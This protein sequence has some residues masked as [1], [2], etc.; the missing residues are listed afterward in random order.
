LA[1]SDKRGDSPL[2][3]ACQKGFP[4]GAQ[5][6]EFLL[7]A[8][9]APNLAG[10]SGWTPL[11]GA[12]A[13]NYREPWG[14]SSHVIVSE[15]LKNGA[16]VNARSRSGT[17]ALIQPAGHPNR[18]DASFV[19]ELIS[20][21]ADVNAADDDGETALMAAAENG[22]VSK[23]K[24]LLA[25]GANAGAKDKLGKTALQYAR[26]PR[27]D[28]DDEFPQ[29]YEKLSSDALKPTNNCAETRKLLKQATSRQSSARHLRSSPG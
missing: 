3:K 24:L 23:V 29:C 20:A 28:Q 6:T 1:V 19:S 14:V 8:G 13:F 5:I 22:H 21:G 15:L 11:M 16:K 9:A 2:S 27:N 10:E 26:P 18:D 12:E 25:N 4:E 17:T 7:S